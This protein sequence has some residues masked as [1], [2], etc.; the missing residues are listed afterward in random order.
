MCV[1]FEE[2]ES[3]R[4][5]GACKIAG[6]LSRDARI[7]LFPARRFLGTPHLRWVDLLWTFCLLFFCPNVA[8][9]T[10]N[11][12]TAVISCRRDWIRWIETHER[13]V[14]NRQL[15][16]VASGK[17]NNFRLLCCAVTRNLFEAFKLEDKQWALEQV[18]CLIVKNLPNRVRRM[19]GEK[20]SLSTR[21]KPSNTTSHL[22]H[23]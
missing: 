6:F 8:R 13:S 23:R 15:S 22:L 9:A 17:N 5:G 7:Q 21:C 4:G 16:S 10:I 18:S 2:P 3:R 19:N 12:S 14:V 20:V 1:A 11:T